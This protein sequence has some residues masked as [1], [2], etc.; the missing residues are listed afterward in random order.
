[1]LL[2]DTVAQKTPPLITRCVQDTQS[3][4]GNKILPEASEH[5]Y[6]TLPTAALPKTYVGV[7]QLKYEPA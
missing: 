4:V 1:M 2:K 6:G 5:T 7:Y 3:L